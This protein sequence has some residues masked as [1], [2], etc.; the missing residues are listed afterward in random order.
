MSVRQE[1]L[2]FL[3]FVLV[4]CLFS[5]MYASCVY[6]PCTEEE[7]TGTPVVC[8]NTHQRLVLQPGKAYCTCP[9]TTIKP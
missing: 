3:S 4:L 5:G 2:L 6:G 8:H 7:I 9:G 1:I